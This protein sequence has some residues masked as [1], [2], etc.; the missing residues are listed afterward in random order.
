VY[1]TALNGA[2]LSLPNSPHDDCRG[3][4]PKEAKIRIDGL[5]SGDDICLYTHDRH[6]SHVFLTADVDRR[7]P[8][9][10]LWHVTRKR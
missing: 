9:I 1:M 7:S 3:V 8:Q 4:H 2:A 10:A 5:G 6:W